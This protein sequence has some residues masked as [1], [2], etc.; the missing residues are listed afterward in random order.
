MSPGFHGRSLLTRHLG[1]FT[2]ILPVAGSAPV[3]SLNLARG[4][5]FMTVFTP[6]GHLRQRRPPETC[7]RS[8][9]RSLLQADGRLPQDEG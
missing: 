5:I 9:P 8:P 7:P 1:Q 3:A 6:H 2:Q 4:D